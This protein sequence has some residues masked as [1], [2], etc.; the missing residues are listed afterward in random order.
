MSFPNKK[1]STHNITCMKTPLGVSLWA[2][3][4]FQERSGHR[5][6]RQCQQQEELGPVVLP[7]GKSSCNSSDG[8]KSFKPE[9]IQL[10]PWIQ[11]RLPNPKNLNP[12]QKVSEKCVQS[13]FLAQNSLNHT[14]RISFHEPEKSE[15]EKYLKSCKPIKPKV[16]SQ[17]Q[18]QTWWIAILLLRCDSAGKL[19]TN[20]NDLDKKRPI[21]CYEEVKKRFW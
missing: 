18:T 6:K 14:F 12:K 16:R 7:I 11:S 5:K 3:G 10:E 17:S 15:P 20:K 9:K 8:L 13:T 2:Q 4:K 19:W 21:L 1:Q